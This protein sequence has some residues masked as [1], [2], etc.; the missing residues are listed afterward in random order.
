[1]F[2]FTSDEDKALITRKMEL[3]DN[4]T[5]ASNSS[6]AKSLFMLGHYYENEYYIETGRKMLNNV[7]SEIESYGSGYSNWAMLLLWFTQP[8]YEVAIVGKSV[9]TIYKTFQKHHLPNVIFAASTNESSLPLLKNRYVNNKTLI[10]VCENKTCLQP[11]K[12][13]SEALKQIT[14]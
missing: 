13:V 3:S 14:R 6:I 10:Y 2:F 5:P 12:E 7:L 1:M 9:D 4:V 11:V 8:F